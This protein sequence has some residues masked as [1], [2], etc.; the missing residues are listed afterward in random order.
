[1]LDEAQSFEGE[2]DAIREGL[3]TVGNIRVGGELRFNEL[4]ARGGLQ[5]NGSPYREDV[6]GKDRLIPSLGLGIR[7]S[8]YFFD[9]SY[10][11]QISNGRY[12]PYGLTSGMQPVASYD[13][14]QSLI[15]FSM[16]TRF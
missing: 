3:R 15:V 13:Q 2:N 7:E 14:L 10:S 16:G 11:L 4:Y 12:Q 5:F 1:M 8:D 6:F 9:V